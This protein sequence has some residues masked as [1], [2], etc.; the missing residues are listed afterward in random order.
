MREGCVHAR[1]IRVGFRTPYRGCGKARPDGCCA[2]HHRSWGI[3]HRR[4]CCFATLLAVLIAQQCN[5]CG[6]LDEGWG[7]GLKGG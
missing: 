6:A 4:H 7:A 3:N 2:G 5:C 1:H